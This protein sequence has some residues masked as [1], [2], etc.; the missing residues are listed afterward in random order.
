MPA[1]R[2]WREMPTT[3]FAGD[4]SQWIAVLPLA[5][6]EQH[7]PH[8]PVGVDALIAEGMVSRCAVALPSES[9][10]VFLPVQQVAK[11]NEHINYYGTLT[12]GWEATIRSWIDIGASVARAGIRKLV[13]VTSHGGNVA[14]MEIAARELRLDHRMLAVTTSWGRLGKWQEIYRSESVFTDIH[15]GEAET[16]LMLALHRDLVDM[17]K[18]DS[19]VSRQADLKSRHEHLGFHS[20]NAN[21]AWLVED[22][23]AHGTVGDASAASAEKGEMDIASTVKG[24]CKL[25]REIETTG[26]PGSED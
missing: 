11:S 13:L 7:G 25:M 2:F 19:F 21:I 23:N 6:I 12:I 8:L 24:F 3:A 20:S 14:A 5:A 1:K 18:A 10:A 26:L 15:G 16:S 22:L 17:S 4:I 9:Q